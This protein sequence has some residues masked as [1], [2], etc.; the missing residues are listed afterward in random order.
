MDSA[1]LTPEQITQYYKEQ[2]NVVNPLSPTDWLKGKQGLT[3]APAPTLPPPQLST[4]SV[5]KADI[6]TTIT[7]DAFKA[8][9]SPFKKAQDDFIK[10]Q[11][12]RQA[13]FLAASAP[14][15][16]ETALT[17]RINQL[18]QE[19]RRAIITA[20][21]SGDTQRFA[22]G[23][24]ARVAREANLQLEGLTNQLNTLVEQRGQKIDAIKT[25]MVF[26]KDNFEALQNL[27]KLSKPDVLSTKVT[28]NG[29]VYSVMQDADGNVRTVKT[30]NIPP[31]PEDTQLKWNETKNAQGGTTIWA[32]DSK[33]NIVTKVIP[34]TAGTYET[35]GGGSYYGDG[36]PS[37]VSTTAKSWL[38]Q[39]NSGLMSIED[40]YAKIGT[41][42]ETAPIRNEV[43]RLVEAQ[44]GKRKYGADDASIQ[45]I[46]SQ[47]QN[48]DELL[49]NKKYGKIVGLTQGGAGLLP[50]IWNPGKQDALAIAKNLVSN[51]TLTALAEAKSKGITFGALSGPE[52]N[53]VSDA[54]SRIAAKIIK[55]PKTEQIIGF[56]GSESQFRKDLDIIREKLQASIGS[57]TQSSNSLANEIDAMRNSTPTT[58]FNPAS[59]F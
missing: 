22:A 37:S 32:V 45:A 10:Q 18:N 13:E 16:T 5:T 23:E 17:Q 12:A 29:D 20:E 3:S 11:Q 59:F 34:G 8:D 33:G 26:D 4:E 48:I 44:G 50:D 42:K 57:K 41:S 6:P 25:M 2:T 27:S 24:S 28:A 40:I 19:A 7:P 15:A 55:D 58:T 51:Q 54:A 49:A 31:D 46:Q 1:T 35:A 36:A 53:T 52:L 30:G 43:A 38:S 39:F 21:G 56:S 9:V 14:S 47:I